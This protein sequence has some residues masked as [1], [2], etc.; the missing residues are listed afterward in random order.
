[1]YTLKQFLFIH[2]HGRCISNS[3]QVDEWIDDVSCL[4]YKDDG[5][6]IFRVNEFT[7]A[8]FTAIE[9][10]IRNKTC[11]GENGPLDTANYGGDV[12]VYDDGS[13]GLGPVPTVDGGGAPTDVPDEFAWSSRSIG[14]FASAMQSLWNQEDVKVRHG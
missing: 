7:E 6:D 5:N 12:W 1:M 4:D 10:L 14:S 13:T 9:E 2:V 11:N 3:V 8:A